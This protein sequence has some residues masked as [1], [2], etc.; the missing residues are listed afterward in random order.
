MEA[1]RFYHGSKKLLKFEKKI[2]KFTETMW[3]LDISCWSNLRKKS[4]SN[5]QNDKRSSKFRPEKKIKFSKRRNQIINFNSFF[6]PSAVGI[7][8]R[9]IYVVLRLLKANI[10]NDTNWSNHK[11]GESKECSS[12]R[13]YERNNNLGT[14]K[15]P[16]MMEKSF[17]LSAF[18]VVKLWFMERR[19]R[20][21]LEFPSHTPQPFNPHLEKTSK[22]I[23][24]GVNQNSFR[25]FYEDSAF[26]CSACVHVGVRMYVV[27]RK[28]NRRRAKCLESFIFTTFFTHQTI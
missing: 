8:M 14:L 10:E 7:G 13:R 12:E 2:E 4:F 26:L 9:V 5:H 24:N 18:L 21:L 20:S 23:A 16:K 3:V 15:M 22:I 25:N 17:F 19:I 6:F 1:T 11:R 27:K 28:T